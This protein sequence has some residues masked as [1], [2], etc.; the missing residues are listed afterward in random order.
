MGLHDVQ[1]D[2]NPIDY[3]QWRRARQR[4]NDRT[5][6]EWLRKIGTPALQQPNYYDISVEAYAAELAALR[7]DSRDH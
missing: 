1:M 3:Q 2:V 6:S 7:R 5:H 4:E